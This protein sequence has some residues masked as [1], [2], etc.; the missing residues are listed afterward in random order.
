MHY[1]VYIYVYARTRPGSRE[2]QPS[3]RVEHLHILCCKTRRYFREVG[4]KTI[5]Q[6]RR[7]VHIYG[8]TKMYIPIHRQDNSMIAK[9]K[10]NSTLISF[11]KNSRDYSLP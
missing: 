5:V 8:L 1:V 6:S 10:K 4:E 2:S 3:V 11:A 7:Y 9:K